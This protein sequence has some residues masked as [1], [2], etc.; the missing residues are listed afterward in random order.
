[1]LRRLLVLLVACASVACASGLKVRS[2]PCRRYLLQQAGVA[3]LTLGTAC[4]AHAKS[5]ASVLPNKVEGTGAN[6]GAYMREQY[7]AEYEAM[8]GDKG[9]RGVASKQF[10][11]NDSVQKNR[12]QNGGVARDKNGKKVATADRNRPPAELGLKQWD[13]K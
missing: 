11:A 4:P 9:S 6:A 7:K 8:A 3:A 5:K 1:M 2:M 10:E 12:M 13:G